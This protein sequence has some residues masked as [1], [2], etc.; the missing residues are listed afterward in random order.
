MSG[1]HYFDPSPQVAS[2]PGEVVLA[3]PDATVRLRTDRGV[4]SASRVDTGSMILL[5]AAPAPPGTGDLLDLGCGY[6][7]IAVTM[8][9]RSPGAT[10]WAVDVNERAIELVGQN[11]A[12]LGLANLRAVTPDAVPGDVR[13]A[14]IWSNPPI[15]VGKDALHRL[16]IDW[17]VRL[18][19][20]G[21]AW[22]VV[23]KHL[24][25]DSLAA[26]LTAAGYPT[27]RRGSKQAYRI[28]EVSASGDGP[29]S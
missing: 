4:F 7:P 12:A 24:G 27:C 9:R 2:H 3:L 13:F 5:R 17:L 15:R 22:L 23:Q 19:A 6:G 20:D 29:A 11:A 25:G 26:W 10:V 18:D 1:G 28:L 8:A 21:R 14:A 16:L